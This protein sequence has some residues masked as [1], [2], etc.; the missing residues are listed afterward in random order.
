MGAALRFILA[1]KGDYKKVCC[2]LLSEDSRTLRPSRQSYR[3]LFGIQCF[4]ECSW[5]H[6]DVRTDFECN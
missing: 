3:E 6:R 4:Q 1:I 2:R 5:I